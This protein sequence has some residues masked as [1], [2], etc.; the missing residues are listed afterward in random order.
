MPLQSRGGS[1][2]LS[3]RIDAL[4]SSALVPLGQLGTPPAG[5]GQPQ[6][7]PLTSWGSDP[8]ALAIYLQSR[9]GSRFLSRRID[10]LISSALVP[11]GQLGT[12][13]AGRGQPQSTPLTSWGS[14]LDA[15]AIYLS[16]KNF[17]V[18]N[19]FC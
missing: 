17:L 15:L 8:D 1:R 4:I 9:G 6:S 10:A 12:P 11:L 13:P 7:T 3:R 16:M 18:D 14:D 2:F 5:R 19:V